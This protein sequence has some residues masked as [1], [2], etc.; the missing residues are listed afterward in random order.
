[1]ALGAEAGL[2]SR[3]ISGRT[4]LFVAPVVSEIVTLEP[5]NRVFRSSN[6]GAAHGFELNAMLA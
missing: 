3:A 2:L 4:S 1:M 6:Y 5:L